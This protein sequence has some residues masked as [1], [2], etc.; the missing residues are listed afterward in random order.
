MTTQPNVL[1]IPAPEVG[2]MIHGTD[3]SELRDWAE[4]IDITVYE[5]F[6]EKFD[7]GGVGIDG[8]WA[9][10]GWIR[11]F[12]SGG[13]EDD[14]LGLGFEGF[15]SAQELFVILGRIGVTVSGEVGE[16]HAILE[17]EGGQRSAGINVN[18]GD[19]IL[20]DHAQGVNGKTWF[21]I[22]PQL[23]EQD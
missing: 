19:L 5:D 13:L 10:V 18:P 22:K 7:F 4:R 2:D 16:E 14:A 8:L 23:T 3:Y 15:E 17:S 20:I 9:V 1:P 6:E 11:D 21:V 12:E